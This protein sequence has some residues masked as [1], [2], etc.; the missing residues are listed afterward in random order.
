VRL[1]PRTIGGLGL[2]VG[3][4]LVANGCREREAEPTVPARNVLI[5][6][7]DAARA[8]HFGCYGYGRDTTPHV[9]R[10]ARGAIRFD[11]A[12]SEAAFTFGSLASLMTGAYPP[13]SGLLDPQRLSEEHEMLAERARAR[14]MR[15]MAYSENPFFTSELGMDQ[16]FDE[17]VEAFPYEAFEAS[18]TDF[19]TFESEAG[20]GRVLDWIDEDP[21]APFFAVVQVLRPHNPYAPPPPFSGRFGSTEEQRRLGLTETLL[22]I[23]EGERSL[24]DEEMSDIQRLYD[25]NLSYADHLFGLIFEG[26]EGRRLL[27][28]TVVV[29]VSDHGEA[30][31]EHGRMLHTSTVFDEMIH[32][33]LLIRWPGYESG[34]VEGSQVQ[35]LDVTRT[36]VDDLMGKEDDYLQGLSLVPFLRRPTTEVERVVYSWTMGH[37]GGFTARASDYKLMVE[38]PSG[39]KEAERLW[40][41][42]NAD[43]GEKKPLAVTSGAEGRELSRRVRDFLASCPHPRAPGSPGDDAISEETK[44]RLRSLGYVQ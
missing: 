20:M 17:F 7:F 29:V 24:D 19:P 16:G 26:L 5:F 44:Q 22:A 41:D 15:T 39:A 11:H 42:L 37:Y 6:V 12:F 23:D 25:E 1:I 10:F 13:R 3:L 27:D 18:A 14:G 9:D 28:N 34:V 40:Y 4:A 31:R 33:P 43:P 36:L 2:A 30:F 21:K 38:R 32:V 8:D 35:L